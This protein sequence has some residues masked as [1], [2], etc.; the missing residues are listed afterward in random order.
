ML[1]GAQLIA[2]CPE[3]ARIVPNWK[4]VDKVWNAYIRLDDADAIYAEVQARPRHGLGETGR[5][6]TRVGR[7]PSSKCRPTPLRILRATMARESDPTAML[8][9]VVLVI[10]AELLAIAV[11]VTFGMFIG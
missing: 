10:V 9:L 8:G 6:Q 7:S 4:I 11:G 3:P 1:S 2:L 5:A